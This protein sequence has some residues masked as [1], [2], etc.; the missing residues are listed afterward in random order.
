MSLKVTIV[1]AQNSVNSTDIS[2][3]TTTFYINT[4]DF[5]IN[6]TKKPVKCS[7]WRIF[8]KMLIQQLFV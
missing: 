5:S 8:F 6:I 2:V 7:E 4:S 1:T 3:E